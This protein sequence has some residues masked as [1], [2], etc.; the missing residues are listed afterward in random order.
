MACGNPARA[1]LLCNTLRCTLKQPEPLSAL[2]CPCCSK[3][4]GGRGFV[5]RRIA[6]EHRDDGAAADAA[7]GGH[8]RSQVQVVVR[9]LGYLL[10]RPHDAQPLREMQYIQAVTFVS[11][12]SQAQAIQPRLT[13]KTP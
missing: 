10:H 13:T 2:K 3:V 9:A 1:H 6:T 5:R 12:T 7:A 8:L 4:K 11:S